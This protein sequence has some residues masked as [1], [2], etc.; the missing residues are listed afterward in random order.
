VLYEFSTLIEPED[1]SASQ[2]LSARPLLKAPEARRLPVSAV[3]LAEIIF[4]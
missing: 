4:R 3:P 2:R 1:V